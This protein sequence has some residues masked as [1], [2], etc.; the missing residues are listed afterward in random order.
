MEIIKI[1]PPYIYSI[2]YDGHDKN[3]YDRLLY[4]WNDIEYVMN[5]LE[6]NINYLQSYIWDNV[7]TPELALNQILNEAEWIELKFEE[8]Y[9]NAKAGRKPDYDTHFHNF[10]GNYD[11]VMEYRPLNLMATLT[12]HC[13]ACMQ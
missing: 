13:Y 3:E 10:G 1:F 7:H 2:Q 11:Y 6:R 8:L 5:F 4:E 9:D 12:H